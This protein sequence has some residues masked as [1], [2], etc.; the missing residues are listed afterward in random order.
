MSAGDQKLQEYLN[1]FLENQVNA[2]DVCWP[3]GYSIVLHGESLLRTFAHHQGFVRDQQVSGSYFEVTSGKDIGHVYKYGKSV[4]YYVRK[5]KNLEIEGQDMLYPDDE[6]VHFIADRGYRREAI[7]VE[8][9]DGDGNK[10]V[11]EYLVHY[12]TSF[13]EAGRSAYK[14]MNLI[15]NVLL[16]A[17]LAKSQ[18]YRLFAHHQGFVRDQQVLGSYFEVTSG[19]GKS[20]YNWLI[21]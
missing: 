21:N 15:E 9:V 1:D 12:G 20:E 4:G 8:S 14:T 6:F 16:M 5:D 18:Y 13:L 7:E 2:D 19:W 11:R 17:R 3:I 10:V